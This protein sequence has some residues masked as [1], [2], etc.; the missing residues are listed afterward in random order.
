VIAHASHDATPRPG[1]HGC[2]RN[3]APVYP[4]RP[5][6]YHAALVLDG[7]VHDAWHPNVRLPPAE[8]VERVF[9]PGVTWELNPGSD[10]EDG[11]VAA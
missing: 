5:L 9:G 11:D 1:L 4:A 3:G 10:E 7:I 8:Y 2:A 6:I